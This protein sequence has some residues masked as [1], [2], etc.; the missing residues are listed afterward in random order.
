MNTKNKKCSFKDHADINSVIYCFEYKVY[1]CNKCNSFHTKLFEKHHIYKID[2]DINIFTNFCQ[3]ENHPNEL[4]YFCKTH[5]KLCCAAC[6]VKIKTEKNGQHKDCDIYLIKDI[7]EEKKSI[8]EE[9]IRILE[10]LGNNF[11][12]LINELK[13]LFEKRN[14]NKELLKKEILQ[15]FT[16]IRKILNERENILLS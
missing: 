8:L 13:V 12:K 4:E 16:K 6:I 9:N 15:I 5:N 1:L 14:E 3:E 2:E 10:D 11:E 7:I